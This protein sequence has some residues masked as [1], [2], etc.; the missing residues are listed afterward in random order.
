[1]NRSQQTT[2]S[3]SRFSYHGDEPE[4]GGVASTRSKN[5][6]PGPEERLLDIS[7]INRRIGMH[8]H[9]KFRIPP[10]DETDYPAVT[11]TV[12]EVEITNAG[13]ALIV[14]G[15]ASATLRLECARCLSPVDMTVEAEIQEE[16]PLIAERNAYNQE[17]IKAVDEDAPAAV[18]TGNIM[19]FGDLLRQNLLLAAP[20]QPRC[21]PEC[22]VAG[23]ISVEEA[24]A[25]AAEE[26]RVAADNPLRRLGDLWRERE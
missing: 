2:E 22:K 7:E 10:W 19:D 20:L 25:Q 16:F 8:Y 18:I 14:R 1:M 26:A 6:E 3:T 9:H 17:E 4:E 24:E 21:E 11:P 12:G 23:V 5:G 13:E 15:R